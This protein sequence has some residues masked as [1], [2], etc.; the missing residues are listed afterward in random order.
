MNFLRH[1]I[2]TPCS[3]CN[4][5]KNCIFI[6]HV[7]SP[8]PEYISNKLVLWPWHH[9]DVVKTIA[10]WPSPSSQT[11]MDCWLCRRNY[12]LLLEQ[13]PGNIKRETW[14]KEEFSLLCDVFRRIAS[15]H[16]VCGLCALTRATYVNNTI[17]I[18]V[19]TSC[20]ITISQLSRSSTSS[21]VS[22][23]R[24][25]RCSSHRQTRLGTPPK[26]NNVTRDIV[27]KRQY[28]ALSSC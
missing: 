3:L 26:Q 28:Y 23:R 19:S 4:W 6:H 13:K 27:E 25:D 21:L 24:G 17:S 15:T 14:G 20:H 9:D 16:L 12:C 8:Y 22:D 7:L 1:V 5:N 18:F 2:S 10:W 11:S